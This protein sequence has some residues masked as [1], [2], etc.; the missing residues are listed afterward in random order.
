[1][2]ADALRIYY[3]QTMKEKTPLELERELSR[4]LTELE[5]YK[6]IVDELEKYVEDELI[7]D[8]YNDDMPCELIVNKMEN[9]IKKLKGE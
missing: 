6:N 2:N 3:N 8:F 5:R 9:M 7:L 1:M 4:A